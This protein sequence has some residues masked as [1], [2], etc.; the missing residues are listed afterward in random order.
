MSSISKKCD[1]RYHCLEPSL[2]DF[3]DVG[4]T[5]AQEVGC[6]TLGDRSKSND[7]KF[8][9]YM[10]F[11]KDKWWIY[12]GIYPWLKTMPFLEDLVFGNA[13]IVGKNKNYTTYDDYLQ[14]KNK[15]N[16]HTSR[17]RINKFVNVERSYQLGAM[18]GW[19]PGGK[20]YNT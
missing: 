3:K 14:M 17:R 10:Q 20:Y 6:H 7:H 1:C 16:T 8:D 2:N 12:R 9:D 13:P 4:L 15:T 5:H 11:V 18:G 19:R